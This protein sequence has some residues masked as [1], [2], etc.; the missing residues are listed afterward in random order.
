MATVETINSID[1]SS[2]T[3]MVLAAGIR[4]LQFWIS[5]SSFRISKQRIRHRNHKQH[6]ESQLLWPDGWKSHQGGSNGGSTRSW[7]DILWSKQRCYRLHQTK[8]TMRTARSHRSN[9][10]WMRL[11]R[12]CGIASNGERSSV[13]ERTSGKQGRSKLREFN[14]YQR[15]IAEVEKLR[16]DNQANWRCHNVKKSMSEKWSSCIYRAMIGSN[17]EGIVAETKVQ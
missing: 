15:L 9:S 3:Q 7:V 16:A 4:C 12:R 8:G 6:P 17:Y 2:R 1:R 13:I 11:R 14:S 10:M 5:T